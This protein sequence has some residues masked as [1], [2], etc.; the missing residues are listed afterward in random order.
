VSPLIAADIMPSSLVRC[1]QQSRTSHGPQMG[2]KRSLSILSRKNRRNSAAKATIEASLSVAAQQAEDFLRILE[3]IE[4]LDELS[5][6]KPTAIHSAT[7]TSSPV[8]K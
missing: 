1:D 3:Q 4:E 8:S 6:Q 7:S 2:Q 5:K